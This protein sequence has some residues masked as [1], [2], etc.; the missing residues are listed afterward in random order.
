MDGFARSHETIGHVT[1]LGTNQH[2]M[3]F[4]VSSCVCSFGRKV[5]DRFRDG[6]LKIIVMVVMSMIICDNK[7][8]VDKWH[9]YGI[10]EVASEAMA[11]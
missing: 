2:G 6:T 10:R 11:A 1:M 3:V 8:V 4:L 7:T 5:I 9:R